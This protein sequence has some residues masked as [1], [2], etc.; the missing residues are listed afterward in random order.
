[1][2]Y[3]VNTVASSQEGRGFNSD[4]GLSVASLHVLPVPALVLSRYSGFFAQSRNMHIR[5]IAGTKLCTGVN[6]E[7]RQ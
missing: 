3:V 5:V 2:H 6:V 7:A 1:M 4:P